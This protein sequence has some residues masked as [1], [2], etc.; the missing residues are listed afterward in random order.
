MDPTFESRDELLEALTEQPRTKPELVA[1]SSVSRSTVDRRIGDLVS[2]GYVEPLDS[3]Y[4]LTEIGR[5][6]LQERRAYRSHM[7]TLEDAAP[8]L[9]T[10]APGS[11][12]MTFLRDATVETPDQRAPWKVLETS[13]AIVADADS[14]T[15]TAPAIVPTIIENLQEGVAHG[16]LTCEFVMD[17]QLHESFDAD[18]LDVLREIVETD[19]GRLFVRP[20]DETHA[21]W[22]S[23][24]DDATYAGVTAYDSGGP[25]GVIFNDDSDAVAWA[26]EQYRQRRASAELVWDFS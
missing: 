18:E 15:G 7:R 3:R 6:A 16:G 19:G 10:V 9:E 24:R 14:L 22:I 25:C 1:A 12:E 21:I 11:I 23:E 26:R 13:Q 2:E 4:R 17:E 5:L 8:I 20:L